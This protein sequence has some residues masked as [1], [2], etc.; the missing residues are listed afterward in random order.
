M[1][2]KNETDYNIENKVAMLKGS[3]I[4]NYYENL[5]KHM[6]KAIKSN[7]YLKLGGLEEILNKSVIVSSKNVKNFSLIY[8]TV[9]NK[10]LAEELTNYLE[11]EEAEAF[12]TFKVEPEYLT[13]EEAESVNS[14]YQFNNYSKYVNYLKERGTDFNFKTNNGFNL[15]LNVLGIKLEID[16]IEFTSVLDYG[17]NINLLYDFIENSN[18]KQLSEETIN[19]INTFLDKLYNYKF[20]FGAY[21]IP[22]NEFKEANKWD[23]TDLKIDISSFLNIE[24]IELVNIVYAKYNDKYL[25]LMDREYFILVEIESLKVYSSEMYEEDTEFLAIFSDYC[26]GLEPEF[27]YNIEFLTYTS[28]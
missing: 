15:L 12:E 7:D 1:V 26:L 25:V 6:L 19:K 14:A 18:I 3:N 23:L 11:L 16:K 24:M 22:Y 5:L 20:D 2:L 27:N 28:H 4:N 13:L 10:V 21:I 9:K 8:A 17:N